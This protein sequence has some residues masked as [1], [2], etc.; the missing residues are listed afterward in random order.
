V[1]ESSTSQSYCPFNKMLNMYL[2]L[3]AIN[4]IAAM[5]GEYKTNPRFNPIDR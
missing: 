4:H 3:L 5:E 2:D 1:S